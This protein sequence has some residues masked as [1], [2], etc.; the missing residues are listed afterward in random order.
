MKYKQEK[1]VHFLIETF[2]GGILMKGMIFSYL[3]RHEMIIIIIEFFF[4]ES[5]FIYAS[6]NQNLNDFRYSVLYLSSFFFI[7]SGKTVDKV[8]SLKISL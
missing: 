6:S 5:M 7:I 2:L 4:L 1:N 8:K 3:S